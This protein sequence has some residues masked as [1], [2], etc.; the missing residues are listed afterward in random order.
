[1]HLLVHICIKSKTKCVDSWHLSLRAHIDLFC[2]IHTSLLGYTQISFGAYIRLFWDTLACLSRHTQIFLL[3]INVFSRAQVGLFWGICAFL[4]GFNR[5]NTLRDCIKER[6]CLSQTVSLQYIERLCNDNPHSQERPSL[7][8]TATHCNPLQLI[9]TQCNSIK[10]T[11]SQCNLLQ[12]IAT[13]YKIDE[14]NTHLH[15]R[16]SLQL[17]ATHCNPLQLTATYCN[18]LQLTATHCNSLQLTT[19]Q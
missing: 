10:L 1:M 8:I 18:L 3:S 19:K 9:A 15:D 6:L 14:G 4:L 12:L 2:G 7:Q 13:H 17:T 16:L 11:A 5:C